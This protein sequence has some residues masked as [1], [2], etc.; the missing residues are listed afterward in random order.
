MVVWTK[1]RDVPNV[2][3]PQHSK[4]VLA[5]WAEAVGGL[6]PDYLIPVPELHTSPP[7]VVA[8]VR[9]LF[10]KSASMALAV[11]DL[12][13]LDGEDV[14]TSKLG[15]QGGLVAHSEVDGGSDGGGY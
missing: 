4:H 2:S 15:T 3:Y 7:T 5:Q 11:V 8:V 12:I 14:T 13:R 1:M 9:V 10:T 6:D